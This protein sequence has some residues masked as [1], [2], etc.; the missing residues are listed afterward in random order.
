MS[1]SLAAV[2]AQSATYELNY[3]FKTLA[4]YALGIGA[5]ASELDYLYEGRGPKAFPS[6]AVVPA[7]PVLTDLIAKSGGNFAMV[8]HGGQSVRVNRPIPPQGTLC[9]VGT[10]SALYDLKRMSQMIM[11]TTS[12][13][14]GEVIC[15]TEW[16]LIFRDEGGFGGPRPA[17]MDIPKIP[18]DQSPSWTHEEIIS[19]EQA[20]L[21]RLSGDLNPLHA[22]P[23]MARS[24]GFEQG[25]ILHGL[26]TYGFV[27]RAVT[28]RSCAGDAARIRFLSAQFK[29]PV[30][31]GETLRVVGYE[32]DDKVLLEAFANDR[33]DAVIAQSW[34]EIVR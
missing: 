31:P 16:S 24:V 3:D 26:A 29:K 33:P 18:K 23:E 19:P 25:P 34:A 22:D 5:K 10:I 1:L 8:V 11:T 27:C 14:D 15:T 12:S 7:Y 6:F 17:K 2:G 30:W 20:L 32:V 4:L 21:Y 9:T 13:L 28:Q